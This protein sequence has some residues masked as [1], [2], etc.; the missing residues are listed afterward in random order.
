ME[1][2]ILKQAATVGVIAPA[3]IPV[4]ER[5]ARGISYLENR[6]MRVKR[7]NNL[8]QTHG[9]FAG[10][11]SQ[12]LSDLHQ[13]FSDPEVD[14][15]IC[16]RGGWGGLRM[17][18]KVDYNLLRN[19]PKPLV[20]Y[21]D[22]T[23]LQLAIWSMTGLPSFSGPMVAVEMGKGIETFTETHFW[24]QLYN[25]SSEYVLFLSECGGYALTGGKAQG[26]LLGGC[27]SM[28]AGL[29]GTPF[30]PDLTDAILFLE[31]IGEKPY[32]IDRYLAQLSQAGVFD[33]IGGLILGTFIDCEEEPGEV[34]FTLTEIFKDYFGQINIPVI[35]DFPYGHGARK[36]T[37]PIG[38]IAALDATR[39]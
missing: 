19:H 27:L 22:V 10:N 9:Y 17:V 38:S 28:V 11:D 37:M 30:F 23:T 20:G 31:D 39:K 24:E 12:R 1:L 6:G 16:A 14:L 35:L 29:L 13:M 36:V 33:K 7:G 4:K 5:L 18:D 2:P 25:Q 26:T 8:M 32:K 15:I 34:S 21:S 3:Y